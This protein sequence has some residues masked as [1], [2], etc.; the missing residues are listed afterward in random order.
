MPSTRVDILRWERTDLPQ[1]GPLHTETLPV[2]F[3][4]TIFV[5]TWAFQAQV[6]RTKPRSIDVRP[7]QPSDVPRIFFQVNEDVQRW[8]AAINSQTR[9]FRKPPHSVD[10]RPTKP[11]DVPW[12]FF[13]ANEDIKRFFAAIYPETQVFRKGERSKDFRP[14][15]P[16]DGWIFFGQDKTES[17]RRYP[18]VEQLLD[19]F[20]SKPRPGKP[21]GPF[22]QDAWFQTVIDLVTIVRQPG[23]EQLR[24]SFRSLDG[25]KLRLSYHKWIQDAWIAAGGGHLE[26]N[27]AFN[28]AFKQLSD[29]FKSKERSKDF[30]PTQPD[31]SWI[32]FL[33]V[34]TPAVYGGIEQLLRTFRS[35]ERESERLRRTD[36]VQDV[37]WKEPLNLFEVEFYS[38]IGKQQAESFRLRERENRKAVLEYFRK[39]SQDA[40]FVETFFNPNVLPAVFALVNSFRSKEREQER[41][42][43]TH[44]VQDGPLQA[45]GAAAFPLD[46]QLW[47]AIEQ[48]VHS[49]QSKER[50]KDVRPTQPEFSWM[51]AL[52]QLFFDPA[53]YP[54]IEQ[55]ADSLR[56]GDRDPDEVFG[57]L[58]TLFSEAWITE[59]I[60]PPPA[61]PDEERKSI[62]PGWFRSGGTS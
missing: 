60:P 36:H 49:F 9:S 61:A 43:K 27:P 23:I 24:N 7:T 17:A 57:L 35:E 56:E 47:P 52:S 41:L 40:Y 30:R 13:Q 51:G 2:P 53:T 3:D 38:G 29:S 4:P 54:A 25:E 10:V 50:S 5:G 39:W 8:F 16:D 31:F 11:S 42:R 14:T 1:S 6:F 33:F 21:L 37:L 58:T 55:L 15:Q 22:I 46:P 26:P 12:L 34:F 62:P 59:N 28:P 20:R 44:Y 18:A 45:F 32:G 19:S 48:L